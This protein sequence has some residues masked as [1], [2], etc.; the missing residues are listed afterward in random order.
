MRF[1]LNWRYPRTKNEMT[2]YQAALDNEAEAP[3]KLRKR[4]APEHLPNLWDDRL[5]HTQRNW[6]RYRK[7]QWR[8]R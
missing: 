2:Q 3:I 6:K 7:T 5:V 4:R 8:I 1:Y